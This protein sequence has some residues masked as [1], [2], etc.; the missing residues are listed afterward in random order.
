MIVDKRVT[1]VLMLGIMIWCLCG[2]RNYQLREL[3]D[4]CFMIELASRIYTK[5]ES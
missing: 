1:V 5:K 3:A 2:F 4:V